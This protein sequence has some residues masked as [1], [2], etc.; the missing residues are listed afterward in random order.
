MLSF[1]FLKINK[2]EL[3]NVSN[4]V[5]YGVSISLLSIACYVSCPILM[6]ISTVYTP[7]SPSIICIN[8]DTIQRVSIKVH[9]FKEKY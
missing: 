1:I 8:L 4:Q 7:R 6:A 5:R 9:Q 2:P 3:L